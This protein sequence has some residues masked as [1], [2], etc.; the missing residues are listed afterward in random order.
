MAQ[1]CRCS[2]RPGC[3]LVPL[4]VTI[5]GHCHDAAHDASSLHLDQR[6][7]WTTGRLSRHETANTADAYTPHHL[8]EASAGT[9][10]PAESPL[11]KELSSMAR[12]ACSL[13]NA[14]G[15][16]INWLLRKLILP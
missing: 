6:A 3:I 14:L 8:M 10:L 2:S 13:G 1:A 5:W 11:L 7:R 9:R 15:M 4:R 12:W 16:I